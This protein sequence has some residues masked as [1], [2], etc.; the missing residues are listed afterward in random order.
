MEH[1]LQKRKRVDNDFTVQRDKMIKQVGEFKFEL[2]NMLNKVSIMAEVQSYLREIIKIQTAINL[3]EE[4]DKQS[5]ALYGLKSGLAAEEENEQSKI[6]NL[7][8][9][10]SK[11]SP[12]KSKLMK[13][14]YGGGGQEKIDDAQV[15]SLNKMCASCSGQ[16]QHIVKMFKLACL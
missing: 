3:Q 4:L 5:V 10:G 16:N 15:I 1:E 8:Q 13:S 7:K 2:D 12:R 14:M 11:P 6:I 9:S